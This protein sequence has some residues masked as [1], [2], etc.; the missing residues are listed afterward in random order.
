VS[1]KFII[2]EVISGVEGHCLVVDGTR[3]A[4][5]KPWGGGR[6]VHTWKVPVEKLKPNN[7]EIKTSHSHRA[8]CPAL[9]GK[10]VCTCG[11]GRAA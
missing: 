5:P 7:P 1:Q 4:G 11:T 2:V 3:I 9:D 10:P 6:V 8:G